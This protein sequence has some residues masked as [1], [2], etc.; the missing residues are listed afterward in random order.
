MCSHYHG[1]KHEQ[2]TLAFGTS[3]QENISTDLWPGYCGAFLR[4]HADADADDEAVSPIEVLAGTFGLLPFWAKSTTLA[5]STYN[6]RSETAAEK[7]SF[8]NAWK[9][10]QFCLIPAVSIFE[11]DWR[12]GQAVATEISRTDGE[13][14]MIAG[15]W[16]HG[17][18]GYSYT[19]LT[20]DASGHSVM[21]HMHKGAEKR[22]VAVLPAAQ[23]SDWLDATPE[24]A[25]DFVQQYPAERLTA[26]ARG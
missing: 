1:P 20:L 7:P 10:R 11:P 8:R 16:E 15:L 4:R 6:A 14:M 17:P 9:N 22:M 3:P 12:T 2:L 24:R 23:Y 26:L 19:M 21:H 5:R 18:L 13:F 25:M